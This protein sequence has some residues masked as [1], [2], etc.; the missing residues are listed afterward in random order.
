[1]YSVSAVN[2]LTFNGDEVTGSDSVTPL[3]QLGT[4]AAV[5]TR[6]GNRVFRYVKFQET[7]EKGQLLSMHYFIDNAD[8]DADSTTSQ[9]TLTATGDF[10][11]NEFND[12]TYRTAFV[13]TDAGTGLGQT[14]AI[15]SNR[16]STSILTTDRVWDTALDATTDY[17]T[18]DVN[19][20]QLADLDDGEVHPYGVAIQ[21]QTA[22]YY[23][24]VQVEGVCPVVRCVGSTDAIV[25]GKIVVASATDG[26]CK[27]PTAAG[28]TALEASNAF[29][30]ALVGSTAADAALRGVAVVLTNCLGMK[31]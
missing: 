22:N 19:F 4:K 21:A 23:G 27:G 10:T 6:E 3:N 11:A 24:W 30:R 9:K 26:A 25:A 31:M 28:M 15:F 29:G 2:G 5:K 1:M 16:G 8:V 12:G 13:S 18:F 17:V 20:V 7:I 14:H